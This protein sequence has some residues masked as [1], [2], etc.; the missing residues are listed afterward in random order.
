LWEAAV[1]RLIPLISTGEVQIIGRDATGVPTAI[2]GVIFAGISVGHPLRDCIIAGDN[3]R[4]SCTPY[5]DDEHWRS[6]FNDYL[7]LKRSSLPSWTHLQ[8]R[9]A[10][11]LRHITFESDASET[12]GGNTPAPDKSGGQSF[13]AEDAPLIEEMRALIVTGKAK[14]ASSAA[15]AVVSK[16]K[17]LG[18]EESAFERLRRGYGRKYRTRK[19][20]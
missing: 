14:S 12:S 8:V 11:L 19:R 16:A 17:K 15:S 18:S 10:D 9:R 3:P 1:G 13:A 6:C 4:I 2:D 7:D 20:M 5:V